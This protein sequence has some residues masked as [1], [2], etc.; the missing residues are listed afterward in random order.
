MNG[1]I[2]PSFPLYEFEPEALAAPVPGAGPG[3]GARR[4]FWHWNGRVGAPAADVTL[5]WTDD[6]A[7]VLVCTSADAF[8]T[9]S[10]RF[11]TAHLALG[12]TFLPPTGRPVDAGKTARRIERLRDDGGLWSPIPGLVPG[13]VGAEG[14]DC[15]DFTL[16]YTLFEGGAVFVAAIGV[17]LARLAVRVADA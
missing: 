12:G 16:A 10:A 6:A 17:P 7:S 3:G 8:D 9:A 5:A 14:A 4:R 2:E 13:T 1:Y 11:R 15:E